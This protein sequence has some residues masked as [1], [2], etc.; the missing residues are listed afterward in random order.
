MTRHAVPEHRTAP[1]LPADRRPDSHADPE[2]RIPRGRAAAARAR[3]GQAA[4]RFPALGARSADRARGRRAGRSADRLRHLCA[5]AGM[6]RPRKAAA[7]RP[8]WRRR[9]DRRPVRTAARALCDRRRDR[10]ARR[11]VGEERAGAGDRGNARDDAARTRR[12][13]AAAGRR[14]DVPHAHRGGDRQR[15]AGRGRRD[16]VG[17]TAPAR[18]T[19]SSSTTTIRRRC[20]KPRWPSIAPC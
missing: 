9:S 16:A 4:G 10:G 2:R 11:Q 19:S 1:P 12:R 20:G 18:C 3:P 17:R 6:Q 14:P 7:G 15:R 5:G 8:R 13:Q